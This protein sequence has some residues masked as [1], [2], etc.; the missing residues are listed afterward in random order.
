MRVIIND[1]SFEYKFASKEA[2]INA[3]HNLLNI[4][5]ELMMQRVRRVQEIYADKIDVYIEVAE[6]YKIIQLVQEFRDK[7]DRRR[8][9]GLLMNSPTYHESDQKVYIDEKL[10]KAGGAAYEDGILVSLI[11]NVIF[12]NEKVSGKCEDTDI[13]IDNLSYVKHVKIHSEKLGIRYY[14]FN[15]KH[16]LKAYVRS[17]GMIASEM[18]LKEDVAQTVLDH[19]I[20]IDGHLYGYYNENFYEFRKTEKNTYHGYRNRNLPKELKIA[21]KEQYRH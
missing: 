11:S 20:E 9:L 4:C 2:A 16:G 5:K 6:D 12:E 1:I 3:F 17:G 15:K 10:S 7:E 8:L 21:I 14:E 13:E 19:S 18:D